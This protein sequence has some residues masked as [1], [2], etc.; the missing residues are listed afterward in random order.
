VGVGHAGPA[1]WDD[2]SPQSS[3]DKL[4]KRSQGATP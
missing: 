4:L 2:V 3:Q 1:P